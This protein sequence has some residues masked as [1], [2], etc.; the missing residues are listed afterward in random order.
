MENLFSRLRDLH[1]CHKGIQFKSKLILMSNSIW[2]SQ[3]T[4][5]RLAIRELIK[6][7]RSNK[8]ILM[9]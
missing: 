5:L 8:K 4:M 7:I 1:T 2:M 6:M 3:F 9:L